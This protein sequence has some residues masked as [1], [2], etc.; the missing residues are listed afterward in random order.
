MG[1]VFPQL[2][3]LKQNL[4]RDGWGQ[5][6][7]AWNTRG[8]R[9]EREEDV[10]LAAIVPGKTV[11]SPFP[12]AQ[13]KTWVWLQLLCSAEGH[14]PSRGSRARHLPALLLGALLTPAA[15][16]PKA[17][18]IKEQ[19]NTAGSSWAWQIFFSDP[20]C[21]FLWRACIFDNLHTCLHCDTI[22]FPHESHLK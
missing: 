5:A 16:L 14:A 7:R 15:L 1:T 8:R 4:S 21:P 3:R 13:S 17:L 19:L 18:P 9:C 12:T 2:N 20:L 22:S 11:G 10:N 6:L